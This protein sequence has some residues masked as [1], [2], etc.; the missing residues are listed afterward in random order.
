MTDK[1]QVPQGA[2][3]FGTAAKGEIVTIFIGPEKK[4]YNIHKDVICHHSE[5]F[6]T[7]YNGRW[8]ESDEG[9]TL[10]DI[11]VEVFN[12]FVHW[13]YA[14]TL[15]NRP[16]FILWL[17]EET[18]P[19]SVL[20]SPR[21]RHAWELVLKCG[22]FGDRFLVPAFHRLAHN[23]FVNEHF[24]VVDDGT[25]G[26]PY[27]TSIWAFDNLP[28]DNP[29]LVMMVDLQ[30]IAWTEEHDD[31]AE[32]SLM[33]QLPN[34]FLVAV[35]LK[36]NKMLQQHQDSFVLHPCTYHLH[37]SEEEKKACTVEPRWWKI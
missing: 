3:V 17:A 13:L 29:I 14:Q 6:R 23:T 34:E 16:Q 22:I 1:P 32:K 10:E 36:Q 24:E 25:N 15:P 33:S 27:E 30:C 26:I 35:M 9:V 21:Y 18:D 11:E 37:G 12:I 4:R 28:K 2:P 8:K 7:A 20:Y 5:Y 19:G 31:E